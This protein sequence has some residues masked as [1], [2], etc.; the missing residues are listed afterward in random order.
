[1]QDQQWI[2]KCEIRLKGLRV[3]RWPAS[4]QQMSGDRGTSYVGSL[5]KE[6]DDRGN[7]SG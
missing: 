2:I 5:S 6:G 3:H 4:P 7:S 1:M